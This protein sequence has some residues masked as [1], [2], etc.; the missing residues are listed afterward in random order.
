MSATF[1]RRRGELAVEIDVHRTG[2][3]PRRE[4]RQTRRAAEL[5][6]NVKDRERGEIGCE[7]G[8]RDQRVSHVATICVPGGRSEQVRRTLR[9]RSDSG[10]LVRPDSG[11]AILG[12]VRSAAAQPLAGYQR[13]EPVRTVLHELVA[14]H[15]QTMLPEV[16]V[17]CGAKGGGRVPWAELLRRAFA[18]DVLTCPCGGRRRV[19][20]VVIDSAIARA[21]LAALGL[22]YNP[23]TFAPARAP[24]QAEFWF[25]DAPVA[26]TVAERSAGRVCAEVDPT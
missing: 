10:D 9:R 8:D 12:R 2:D 17:S 13:R 15:A 18:A 7:L 19:V 26:R 11:H 24:P 25:P 16:R 14:Q 20:A 21:L 4:L 5:V 6:A 3:M 22:P 1:A 23:A